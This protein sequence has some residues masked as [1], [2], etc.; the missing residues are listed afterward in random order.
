[1]FLL[2]LFWNSFSIIVILLDFERFSTNKAIVTINSVQCAVVCVQS[3]ISHFQAALCRE[4]EVISDMGKVSFSKPAVGSGDILFCWLFCLCL[5]VKP[6][7]VWCTENSEAEHL[8][9]A[10]CWIDKRRPQQAL[11]LQGC[12]VSGARAS[13]K[14]WGKGLFPPFSLSLFISNPSQFFLVHL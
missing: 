9:Q 1:M 14:T 11:R 12:T 4:E 5:R 7:L 6:A 2:P 3:N 10:Q 8:H 13:Q